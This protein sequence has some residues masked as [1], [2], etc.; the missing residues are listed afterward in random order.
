MKYAM[1]IYTPA[2]QPNGLDPQITAEYLALRDE[3]NCIDGAGLQSV[4]TATTLRVRDGES[5]VTDGP[6]ADTKEVFAGYYVFELDD[7]DAALQM[8]GRIPALRTGGAVEI[9]AVAER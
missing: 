4:E 1:L 5:L 8:A 2:G 6:F 9:R 3:P 7:L